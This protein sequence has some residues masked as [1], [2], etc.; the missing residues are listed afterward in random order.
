MPYEERQQVAIQLAGHL[1]KVNEVNTIWSCIYIGRNV[2]DAIVGYLFYLDKETIQKLMQSGLDLN[3]LI[4]NG[5]AQFTW[6]IGNAENDFVCELLEL[7]EKQTPE[8]REVWINKKDEMERQI[9]ITDGFFWGISIKFIKSPVKQTP[10]QLSVAKGYKNY[11]RG[12]RDDYKM[13]YINLDISKKLLEL[14]AD[15]EVNYQEPAKGN[16]A[17]HI[18]YARRDLDSIK[19]L[20]SFGASREIKNKEGKTPDDM[21]EL[22]F[23][24]ARNLLRFHTSPDGH[25]HTFLLDKGDFT[26]ALPSI[27]LHL[28]QLARTQINI[29]S[30]EKKPHSIEARSIFSTAVSL[31][32]NKSIL[33]K[34][35]SIIFPATPAKHP[36]HATEKA[37][38]G[39]RML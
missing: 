20:E 21:L 15:K 25:R 30:I 33:Q 18:A 38:R 9:E 23:R 5:V 6:K 29:E 28:S 13:Q 7:A 4:H 8:Q 34:M 14:G 39:L 1:L 32:V 22:N 16:T 17:L 12:G 3:P 26:K 19:L 27:K 2:K 10:L 31:V 35:K 24:Q 36:Q 37:F 11:A